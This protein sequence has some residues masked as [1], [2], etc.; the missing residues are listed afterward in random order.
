MDV[1]VER[2]LWY[3]YYLPM[4]FIPQAAVQT[5]VLLGQPGRVHFTEVVKAFICSYNALFFI[6]IVK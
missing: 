2:Y 1:N 6:G 3:S 4:L 5:A